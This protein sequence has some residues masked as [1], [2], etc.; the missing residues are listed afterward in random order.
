[1]KHVKVGSLQ[2]LKDRL[3]K[4]M[5]GLTKEEAIKSGVCVQCLSPV[6]VFKDSLSYKEYDQSGFCQKCQDSFF[7]H[8]TKV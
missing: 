2:A 3:A 1:M 6:L 5:A 7:T 8:S 4:E